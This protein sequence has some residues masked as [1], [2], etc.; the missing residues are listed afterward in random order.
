MVV[1]VSNKMPGLH[2]ICLIGDGRAL[3]RI[4][5]ASD[6]M[7][8]E[9]LLEEY[10]HVLRNDCPIPIEDDHDSIFWAVLGE[11]TNKWRGQ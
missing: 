5:K 2:G 4:A 1:R 6:Q 10:C 11:V 7:M 3:I 9:T 8:R